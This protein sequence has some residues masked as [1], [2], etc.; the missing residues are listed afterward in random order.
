MQQLRRVNRQFAVQVTDPHPLSETSD[1]VRTLYKWWPGGNA[2]FNIPNAA[3]W[4]DSLS[5]RKWLTATANIQSACCI[6][7]RASLSRL[8]IAS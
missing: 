5:L 8:W 3:Q 7:V 2:S 6:A 4:A 1:P